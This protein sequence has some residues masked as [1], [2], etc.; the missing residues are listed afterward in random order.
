MPRIS[1]STL[2]W[3]CIA[4][5]LSGCAA[6]PVTDSHDRDRREARTAMM[7][8][9]LGAPD[10]YGFNYTRKQVTDISMHAPDIM[11]ALF[12]HCAAVARVATP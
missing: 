12:G 8:S 5:L 9:C 2:R 10:R 3:C 6:Q 1:R 4:L 11:D 7:R